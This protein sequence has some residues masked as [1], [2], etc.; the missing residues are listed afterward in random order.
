VN[1][2]LRVI[3]DGER[4]VVA[5]W[6][7]GHLASATMVN[8]LHWVR[9]F[10][11]YCSGHSLVETQQL[12]RTGV[13]QFTHFYVG[14]RLKGRQPAQSTCDSARNAV[15]AWA[16]AV[17]ALGTSV[18]PW[19]DPQSPAPLPPLL[20]EFCHFRQTHHG[21]AKGS[22]RRDIDTACGFLTFLRQRHK[23]LQ[24]AT[25]VDVD[26]FVQ[27]VATRVSKCTVVSAC[28]SL[29]I[30]LR[31]LQTTGRLPRD[32]GR[33]VMAPRFSF[34][35]RPPRTLRWE[36][37]KRILR[38]ICRTQ[39]PGRRDFAILLLLATYGLGAAEAL[40]LRLE[41]VDWRAG[42]LN[43]YRPKTKVAIELPLLP[44]VAQALTAYLRWE[45]PPAKSI[46]YIF[47]RTN[48]PYEPISSGALRHRIRH[49]ASRAGV[50]AEVIGAHAFRHAHASRQIDAGANL[51]V[52]SEILGHRSCSSTSVYVR[53]A[54][55]RLR[56]VGLPV[57]R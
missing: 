18:P 27:E 26:A 13:G 9:L 11:A 45:R 14:A 25:L 31:F 7:R 34:T 39:T 53:V 47:L 6:R 22:L 33:G 54:L 35:E 16:C 57:P 1:A 48:M 17:R 36:E 42:R 23:P 28:S 41:D 30:F 56:A 49:Y 4:A 55:R 32:L 12:T 24:R 19:S 20:N 5:W 3:D 29:R 52:V 50:S 2:R 51:K 8:Y 15:H 46:P 21:V 40:G 44:A 10:R 38:S 37:V 43:V